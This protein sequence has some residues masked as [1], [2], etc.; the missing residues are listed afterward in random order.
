MSPMAMIWSPDASPV[1]PRSAWIDKVYRV[2]MQRAI[3]QAGMQP[4]RAEER[5]GSKLVHSDVSKDLRDRSVILAD[6]SLE[7]PNVFYELGWWGRSVPL[8]EMP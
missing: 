5:K 8:H 4:V 6:L 3:R 1:Q 2:I 7:N